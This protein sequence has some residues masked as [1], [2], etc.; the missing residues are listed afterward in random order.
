MSDEAAQ[1]EFRD[2]RSAVMSQL[3]CKWRW[4]GCESSLTI[5]QEQLERLALWA[6]EMGQCPFCTADRIAEISGLS[7]PFEKEILQ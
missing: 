6:W 1:A 7:L 2:Y 3:K 5:D 4:D